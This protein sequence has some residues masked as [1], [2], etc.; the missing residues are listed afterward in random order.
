MNKDLGFTNGNKPTQWNLT[1][2]KSA[3]VRGEEIRLECE[4]NNFPVMK[5]SKALEVS[6]IRCVY[7]NNSKKIIEK[8]ILMHKCIDLH[9]TEATPTQSVSIMFNVPSDIPV[10]V[11]PESG[12][13]IS[14]SYIIQADLNMKG[15][16]SAIKL[17]KSY[18]LEA[19]IV[20][21]TYSAST[22]T[23]PPLTSASY[24]GEP[25]LT[26]RSFHASTPTVN[27]N[28]SSNSTRDMSI[29]SL[30]LKQ[31]TPVQSFHAGLGDID[32]KPL[33][34]FEENGDNDNRHNPSR[35]SYLTRSDT[36][37]TITS[38]SYFDQRVVASPPASPPAHSPISPIMMRHQPLSPQ[39]MHRSITPL[40][41]V[42]TNNYYNT[43]S[44]TNRSYRGMPIMLAQ[45]SPRPSRITISSPHEIGP[46][47]VINRGS[48]PDS[49]TIVNNGDDNEKTTYENFDAEKSEQSTSPPSRVPSLTRQSTVSTSSSSGL[50]GLIDEQIQSYTSI[51]SS[52]PFNK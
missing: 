48:S 43:V 25:S 14:V 51:P 7:R 15:A 19:A 49:K 12:R 11:F 24:R 30:P 50:I 28:S 45:T 31:G 44:Y 5:K 42:T 13:I 40:P 17:K 29:V 3:F 47:D 8:K 21:G 32:V 10:S 16:K 1:S 36:P 4:F 34:K 39:P 23:P 6:F 18:S 20:I 22:E 2:S 26:N 41:P 33:A 35:R 37:S 46:N 9:I 38:G 27:R 52:P